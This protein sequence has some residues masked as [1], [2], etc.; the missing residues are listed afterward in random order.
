M[1]HSNDITTTVDRTVSSMFITGCGNISAS[2]WE[3][4]KK[5]LWYLRTLYCFSI[6]HKEMNFHM[7]VNDGLTL[8]RTT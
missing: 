8:N 4:G 5:L 7:T 6:R 1:P 3:S 2:N